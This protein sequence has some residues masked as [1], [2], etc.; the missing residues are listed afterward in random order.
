MFEL[1]NK[2][3]R[4]YFSCM[5]TAYCTKVDFEQVSGNTAFAEQTDFGSLLFVSKIPA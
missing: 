1:V 4:N 3:H 2:T 5:F